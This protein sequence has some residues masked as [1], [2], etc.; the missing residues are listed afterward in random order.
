MGTSQKVKKFLAFLLT[1]VLTVGLLQFAPGVRTNVEAANVPEA[2]H[3]YTLNFTTLSGVTK[4]N[5][6][7]S[8]DGIFKVVSDTDKAYWHDGQ[9]GAALYNG[10]KIEVKVAGNA[11]IQL[12][13]C[14]YG[15]ATAFTVTDE[16]G[17]EIGST[18]GKGTQDG[19][20]EKVSY[21]GDATTLT[22]TCSANAEAYLHSVT[23]SN[24]AKEG[25]AENFT[26]ML[27]NIAKKGVVA[28]GDYKYG[29]SVLT[30]VGQGSTQYTAKTGKTVKVNGKE[31]NSYTAGKRHANSDNMSTIPQAGD[32]TLT[33]FT[34]AAKGMMT[35][36]FNSVSSLRVYDFNSGDGSKVGSTLTEKGVTSYSFAV[37]PGHTYVMSTTSATDNLF[38]AGYKYVVDKT[39]SVPVK[40]NNVN[41]NLYDSLEIKA[42]DTELSNRSVKLVDGA[43]VNLLE[44]H[45]YR[46]STND[47]SVKALVGDSYTFTATANELVVSLY[48]VPDATVKGTITGTP[49]G[50][51]KELTFENMFNG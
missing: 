40:F 25:K 6:Y 3:S 41:A 18:S 35:V 33:K 9:H 7:T 17:K 31:Y 20:G 11:D 32:G 42:V 39:V 15:N 22:I 5:E 12:G 29:D 4:L 23:V 10:D 30:L 37:A 44:G 26:M 2:G 50:T 47:T 43:N 19:A 46:L 14:G 28:T 38:Y 45:T 48:D 49:A 21:S 13:L 36:Y 24:Y 8:D 16:A 1:T 51:V 34:P 27:D